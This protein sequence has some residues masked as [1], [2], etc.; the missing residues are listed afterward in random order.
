MKNK[1]L[2]ISPSRK[3][4]IIKLIN[5]RLSIYDSF[6]EFGYASGNTLKDIKK[7]YP[8]KNY[9]GIDLD[10]HPLEDISTIKKDL[11]NFNFSLLNKY[12]QDKSCYILFDVLE[13]LNDP[14]K[15]LKNLT[16]EISK[17]SIILISCPNFKSIRFLIAY[18]KGEI[19]LNDSGFFDRTHIRWMTSESLIKNTELELTNF[20]IK[21]GYIYSEKIF[22]KIF[23]KILPSRFCSQFT[24]K[25]IK[26]N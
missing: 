9:L 19:P 10:L 24:L 17:E 12:F 15:F 7:D 8:K 14:W 21:S 25:I 22:F 1:Y 3:S 16:K 18:F 2:D 13:H 23:Q 26:L 11:N 5:K 20:K 6:I 4:L